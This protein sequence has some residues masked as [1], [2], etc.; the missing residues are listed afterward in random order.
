MMRLHMT[1]K[2]HLT[3][4]LKFTNGTLDNWQFF[5]LVMIIVHVLLKQHL[6]SK[7][8]LTFGTII[9]NIRILSF[10]FFIRQCFWK[11][12]PISSFISP[13][14]SHEILVINIRIFFSFVF[15][16]VNI[17]PFIIIIFI[18]IRVLYRRFILMITLFV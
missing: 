9:F 6:A 3:F 18:L 12:F 13:I 4:S 16:F 8:F 7:H 1:H 17:L 2:L 5:Y 10:F 11:F 14:D 15:I